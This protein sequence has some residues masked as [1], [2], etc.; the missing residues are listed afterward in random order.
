MCLRIRFAMGEEKSK[1]A[2]LF[3]FRFH[4]STTDVVYCCILYLYSWY[5]HQFLNRI[6]WAHPSH[7]L[8]L[9]SRF[10]LRNGGRRAAAV[11]WYRVLDGWPTLIN[12]TLVTTSY[13]CLFFIVYSSLFLDRHDCTTCPRHTYH[14]RKQYLVRVRVLAS[15]CSTKN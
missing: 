1:T 3:A 11:F 14:S 12:I 9:S 7:D 13:C 4:T 15:P 8:N 10:S 2:P 6:A 5:G